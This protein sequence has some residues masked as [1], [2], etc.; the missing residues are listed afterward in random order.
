MKFK[1]K[2]KKMI[3]GSK[4]KACLVHVPPHNGRGTKTFQTPPQ[5]VMF[6]DRKALHISPEG[7]NMPLFFN[8][9]NYIVNYNNITK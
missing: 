5:K 7:R 3:V 1:E 2:K 4:L 9:I 8:N 6:S